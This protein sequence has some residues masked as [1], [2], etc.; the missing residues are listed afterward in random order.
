MHLRTFLK[1][2]LATAVAPRAVASLVTSAGAAQDRPKVL[3]ISGVDCSFC[4]IWKRSRRAAWLASPEYRQVTYIE[5]ESPNLRDAYSDRF[6]PADLR[7]IRDQLPR[8]SGTPRFVMA[9]NGRVVVNRAGRW[10]QAYSEIKAVLS[11]D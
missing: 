1:L 9:M 11:D 6:W 5:I 4:Q 7:A 8:K 10:D 3:F 2:A